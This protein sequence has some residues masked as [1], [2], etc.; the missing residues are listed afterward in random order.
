MDSTGAKSIVLLH[1]FVVD[2]YTRLAM[3]SDSGDW[4]GQGHSYDYSMSNATLEVTGSRHGVHMSVRGADGSWWYGDFRPP[5]GD[6][7]ASGST[8][9][10]A[11][12]YPFNES[13]PGLS[14]HGNGHGC[15]K[16]EGTFTITT[17]SVDDDGSLRSVGIT[18]EQHCESERPALRGSLG[19]RTSLVPLPPASNPPVGPPAPE[20]DDGPRADSPRHARTVALKMG[21]GWGAG[22][23]TVP[24]GPARCARGMNVAIQRLQSGVWR[25]VGRDVTGFRGRYE[26][27]RK[28][29]P[30]R[31]RSFTPRAV[32]SSTSVCGRA[33]ST[34]VR[35]S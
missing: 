22:R 26:L 28:F 17:I 35:K 3:R 11:L 14:V 15:N 25:T 18:F 24:N 21:L 5:S 9:S 2:G 10:G 19:Y 23:L 4:I 31:Y 13:A 1:G 12:R 32:L 6:I 34:S 29:R 7:F 30:G 33:V 20:V 27:H 16:L 8:Y